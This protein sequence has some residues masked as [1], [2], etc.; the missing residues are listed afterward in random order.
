[1]IRK[2]LRRTV[3]YRWT[4]KLMTTRHIV[5]VVLFYILAVAFIPIVQAFEPA[6]TYQINESTISNIA[7]SSDG[8][9]IIA[10]ADRL[11]I[12]SKD[13]ILQKKEQFGNKVVLTPSGRYAVSSFG[14]TIYF[15]STPLTTGI[16]DPK[17]MTK[18]WDMEFSDPV[19]FIDITDSGSMIVVA[20]QGTGIYFITTETKNTLWNYTMSNPIIRLSHDGSRIVGIADET[21]NLYNTYN[22]RVSKSYIIHTMHN[23][24]FVFL[25]QTVPLMVFNEDSRIRSYDLKWGTEIWNATPAGDLKS[26]AMTPS[27]SYVVAGT[28]SGNISRYSDEGN[29]NWSYSSKGENSREAGINNIAISKDGGLIAA[30]SNDGTVLIL[31]Q[32][33]ILLGSS[34]VKDKIRNIALNQDGTILLVTS[35]HDIY[36]FLTAY[37]P[38]P[39]YSSPTAQKT[40]ASAGSLNSSVKNITPPQDLTRKP[41]I[42]VWTKATV[43]DT[44]TEMPTEYSIVRT[45]PTQSPLEHY[46]GIL[47]IIVCII[48]YNSRRR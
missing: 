14:G 12:F 44:I 7:V 15:F 45:P 42:P 29:L 41:V 11:W 32:N 4:M 3:R 2:F 26:L 22:A 39:R 20:M 10:A 46:C 43:T 35:D 30:A 36:A 24:E 13:G 25:S 21:I 48:L 38:L 23:P 17:K 5:V 33:G 28:E 31:N 18:M 9:T 40:T 37:T 1:M 8:S 16:S 6:W 47:A 19:R 27:G 34:Q